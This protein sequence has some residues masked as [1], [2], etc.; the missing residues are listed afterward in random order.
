MSEVSDQKLFASTTILGNV[1]SLQQTGYNRDAPRAR[2][3]Q[4]IEIVDLDSA[5]AKN[6]DADF[7]MDPLNPR[8]S[9]RLVIWFCWSREDWTE[10]DVIG[11]FSLR[12]D[13]LLQTVRGFSGEHGP[14]GF[15]S[16]VRDRI[17]ILPDVHAFNRNFR[18]DFS[19]IVDDQRNSS[20]ESDFVERACKIDNLCE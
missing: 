6:R 10:A 5:D 9:N 14:A 1:R 20:L 2:G 8:Q 4:L 12:S 18:R 15:F 11:A 3:N 16:C 19:V 13:R 17:V 7:V